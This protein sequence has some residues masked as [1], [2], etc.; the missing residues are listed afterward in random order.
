MALEEA[1]TI[2]ER[3]ERTKNNV[4]FLTYALSVLQS[5]KSNKDK[6]QHS[7]FTKPTNLSKSYNTTLQWIPAHC[8][9]R[10]NELADTLA[11]QG[12][13]LEQIDSTTTSS[14]S[15]G[16]MLYSIGDHVLPYSTVPCC[17]QDFNHLACSQPVGKSIG[18]LLSLFPSAAFSFHHPCCYEMF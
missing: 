5:I 13:H 9:L 10:G 7:L 17:F 14:S 4:V 3:S 12:A 15:S 11:K 1:A 16:A 6:E 18:H 2:L 8:G